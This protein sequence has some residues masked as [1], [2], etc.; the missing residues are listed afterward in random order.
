MQTM[1]NPDTSS[2]R[3]SDSHQPIR[4]RAVRLAAATALIALALIT[5]GRRIDAP[6]IQG[7]EYMFI[8][9][10]PDVTGDGREEPFWRR[11]ADIFTHVHNDLYQPIPILTYAIEWRIWGADSAAPMR[12]ADLLIHAINAVLIWR[13][14]ARLLLRPGDA[15]DTAVE[16]LCW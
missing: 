9:H 4:R 6:W 2:T 14:L 10:N 16:A 5:G 3:T 12:L 15:P 8:V 11:C 13:L 1:D 7:D